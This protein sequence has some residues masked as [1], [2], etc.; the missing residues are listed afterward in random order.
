MQASD[1]SPDRLRELAQLHPRSGRVLSL[2]LNLDPANFATGEARATEIK[3]LLND[4]ERQARDAPEL[5]HD[6]RSSLRADIE[7]LR[8][9]LQG[10]G[11]SP[12]G[13]RALAVFASAPANL[14]EAI[15]LPR[16]IESRV[17]IDDSPFIEPM[18]DMA[19]SGR[20]A[21]VLVNRRN[22]RLFTGTP[23]RL[24][25]DR[26]FQEQVR[27]SG[28][29]GGGS[30]TRGQHTDDKEAHDHLKVIAD[31]LFRRFK[32]GGFD[33][34]LI[35]CPEELRPEM[36]GRLH[37]QLRERLGGHIKVDVDSAS[38]QAVLA[39]AAPVIEEEDRR[40][41][42]E[43]LDR[44]AEGLGTGG[45]AAAGLDEVLQALSERRVETLLLEAGF[46]SPG[47][48]CPGCGW[49]GT[50]GESCPFDGGRLERRDDVV[51]NAI[52]SAI[53]QSAEVLVMRHHDDLRAQEGIGA[54]LRF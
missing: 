40:R 30:Q 21:V 14:F 9:F 26:R 19:P 18:A 49:L 16:P 46:S 11:F 39:A 47:V 6:D 27:G 13:A 23:E 36:E 45:R 25:E 50:S 7:R 24:E 17:V 1:L 20:W 43:A 33:R 28:E 54:V 51:E 37:A 53:G 15:R 22:G 4:A 10:G 44:L 41:E 52:E 32:R 8:A 38:G 5:S 48:A 31:A 3:S 29:Q 12:K 2:Y 34:L 35:G 42:R